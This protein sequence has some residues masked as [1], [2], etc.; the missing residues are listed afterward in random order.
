MIAF[1]F[2]VAEGVEQLSALVKCRIIQQFNVMTEFLEC[3]SDILSH[4]QGAAVDRPG[5]QNPKRITR[6]WQGSS[7]LDL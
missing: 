1:I 7:H 3:S 6:F 5:D 4:R 2:L